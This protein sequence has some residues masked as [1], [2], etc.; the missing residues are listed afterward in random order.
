[1][2]KRVKGT[3]AFHALQQ[4]HRAALSMPAL[5]SKGKGKEKGRERGREGRG[6]G[7]RR[8]L[9]W[10]LMTTVTTTTTNQP[11]SFLHLCPLAPSLHLP[12]PLSQLPLVVNANTLP[13]MMTALC[14]PVHST[15]Q[16]KN[17]S[18]ILV[19]LQ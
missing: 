15:V 6:K 5:L 2:P 19:P 14:C 10:N 18:H 17:K 9:T 7:R 4:S 1:M 8:R 13:W 12:L 16:A 11:L 3:H